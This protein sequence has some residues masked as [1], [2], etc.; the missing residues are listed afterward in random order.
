M[1]TQESKTA[2]MLKVY[3]DF[4]GNI[5]RLKSELD[6]CKSQYNEVM[7]TLKSEGGTFNDR[8][9]MRKISDYWIRRRQALE[10]CIPEAISNKLII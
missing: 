8:M 1:K 3:N 10:R 5:S 4:Y 6:L 7:L 9:D 2:E